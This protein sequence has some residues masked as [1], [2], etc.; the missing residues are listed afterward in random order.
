MSARDLTAIVHLAGFTTGIILYLM[1]GVMT[2]R[3]L[4]YVAAPADPRDVDRVPLVAALLG[5]IWNAGAMFVYAA[6]DFRIAPPLPWV[7]AVS[8]TALGFL[9]ATVVHS[10]LNRSSSRRLRWT[11]AVAYA[12]SSVAGVLNLFAASRGDLLSPVG[13]LL[14][15]ITYAAVLG[16]LAVAERHRPGFGGSIVAIA[17]AAFAVSALHLSRHPRL[18]DPDPWPVELIGHHASLPLALAILYQDFRFA[19][20]D[21]FLKRALSLLVAVGLVS[22]LYATLAAP[23]IDP[24]AAAVNA[25]TGETS[26]LGATAALLAL[27]SATTL[28]YPWIQRRIFR[29]VD[30]VVLGRADYRQLRIDLARGLASASGVDE[31]LAV[32]CELL[33]RALDAATVNSR[34]ARVRPSAGDATITLDAQRTETC[35][36]VHTAVDPSY[37]IVLSGLRGGRTLL[38][39]DLMLID[40]VAVALGRRIDTLRLEQE[41]AARELRERE[42]Q[43]LATEAE[44]RALRAQLNPHFLFNTLNTLGHLMQAA[45]ERA[46]ATLYRL[47]GLLRAVLRRTDG[48]FVALRDE[49]EIVEAYLAIEHER[50]EERL[51]VTI[52]VPA[53]LR[54]A[55]VPPLLLQPLVENAV[56]HGISPKREGGHVTVRARRHTTSDDAVGVLRLTVSDTGLGLQLHDSEAEGGIGLSNIE[57]RLRLYFGDAATIIIRPTDGGGTTVELEIPWVVAD[58][59]PHA[60]TTR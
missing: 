22:L 42:M 37:E 30:R 53:D 18:V 10:A 11:I 26:H 49:L 44:L 39:D 48:R 32:A 8:Y 12:G 54:R 6:R 28:T 29:F 21:L 7:G 40:F 5:V 57:G 15:T 27:W 43:A 17:L 13:L 2:R 50:F 25:A 24:H 4:A 52:D 23:L 3:R 20:A 19:F 31:A 16:V 59:H 60:K 9:P 55:H 35:I 56:K 38:S 14:L 45:P 46:T 41:R 47:T 1:L 33:V 34:P 58:G 36:V 51:T